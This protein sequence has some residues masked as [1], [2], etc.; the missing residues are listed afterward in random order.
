M[1]K[2]LA[3]GV[4]L[5][6]GLL[7]YGA[8]GPYLTI[9]QIKTAV[10][11]Q[12]AAA[13]AEQVD[14]AALRANIKAQLN[15]RA[16]GGR[17]DAAAGGE[18]MAGLLQ[19]L[20]SKLLDGIVDS[21]ITPDG[22][23]HLIEEGAPRLPRGKQAPSSADEAAAPSASG[24]PDATAPARSNTPP[25]PAAQQ[26]PEP[27]GGARYSFDSVSQ[28]SARVTHRRG[29]ET[30]FVLTRDGLRWKLSNIIFPAPP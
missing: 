16:L 21:L 14:F 1:K 4:L 23:I 5:S 27:L 2:M 18:S 15:A 28:F 11:Q 8:A 3:L 30:R 25:P 9:H 13:L 29:D 19:G 24:L 12:D 7:G 20:A 17:L 26:R 10:R 22:V 6:L